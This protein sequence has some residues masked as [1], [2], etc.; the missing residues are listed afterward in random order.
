MIM[1]MILDKKWLLM[2]MILV[3]KKLLFAN[4]KLNTDSFKEKPYIFWANNSIVWV[5][6]FCFSYQSK[7]SDA[8]TQFIDCP[9]E[10]HLLPVFVKMKFFLTKH[11]SQACVETSVSFVKASIIYGRRTMMMMMMIISTFSCFLVL[12][13]K[14]NNLRI[15]IEN[16]KI[17]I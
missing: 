16:Q 9:A 14:W 15:K 4:S 17:Y 1:M 7:G 13:S 11:L 2:T 5:F 6:T 8:C 12:A 3:E 10:Q